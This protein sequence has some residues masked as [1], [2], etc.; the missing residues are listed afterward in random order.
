MEIAYYVIIASSKRE[1]T[2]KL[3]NIIPC[4]CLLVWSL[5]GLASRTHVESPGKPRESTSILEALPGK[6]DTKIHL[7]TLSLLLLQSY[8]MKTGVKRPLKNRQNKILMT[9]GSSM[10]VESIAECSKGSILQYF[11]PALSDNWCWKTVLSF[12]EWPFYTG[13]IV[14]H[15]IIKWVKDL[16]WM[17][18]I[19]LTYQR[20]WGKDIKSQACRAFH[21][22]FATRLINSIL[23]D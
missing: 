14:T 17:H 11:W 10:K 8:D 22:R 15:S 9:K 20:S 7:M 18:M 21:S 3:I 1:Q 19:L 16:V 4:L 2:C 13:F 6:L 12:W 23:N 5:P